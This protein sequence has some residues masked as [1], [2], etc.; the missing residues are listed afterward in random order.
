MVTAFSAEPTHVPATARTEAIANLID[1]ADHA[2]RTYIAACSKGD[3][4]AVRRIVTDDALFEYMLRD[5]GAHLSVDG[6]AL[7]ATVPGNSRQKG[8]EAPLDV[9]LWIFPTNDSSAVFVQYA[10][11]S[12]TQPPARAPVARYLAMIDM[13]GDRIF[14]MRD[15]TI[16]GSTLVRSASS[17][18]ARALTSSCAG[19]RR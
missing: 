1:R 14:K 16:D 7:S 6:A 18:A 5:P 3:G 2:L 17:V 15:F 10:I 8:P 13:R 11:G 19:A 12:S 9:D 4:E